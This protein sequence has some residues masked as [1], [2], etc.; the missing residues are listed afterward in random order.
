MQSSTNCGSNLKQRSIDRQKRLKIRCNRLERHRNIWTV[1]SIFIEYNTIVCTNNYFDIKKS[2]IHL[3]SLIA[4]V[5]QQP[6]A[7]DI[8]VTAIRLIRY[9]HA[10]GNCNADIAELSVNLYDMILKTDFEQILISA[11]DWLENYWDDNYSYKKGK[12]KIERLEYYLD[13]LD[14]ENDNG[15]YQKYPKVVERIQ[16]LSN[17]YGCMLSME[18]DNTLCRD[19]LHHSN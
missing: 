3:D 13:Y 18:Y 12:A 19:S 7:E 14:K 4:N 9:K 10:Q 8:V 5:K 15:I 2:L 11:Y 6:I 1:M 16:I 17:K